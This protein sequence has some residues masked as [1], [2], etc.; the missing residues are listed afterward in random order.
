MATGVPANDTDAE[1]NPRTVSTFTQ[2]ANGT[3]ALNPNG[4]FTYTVSD[5]QG[6]TA[7]GTAKINV[8]LVNDPPLA[9]ND[10]YTTAEDSTLTV[11]A[12]GLLASD[13]DVDRGTDGNP[14]TVVVA[15]VTQ[16]AHGTVIRNSTDAHAG[17]RHHI[18]LRGNDLNGRGLFAFEKN[19]D[20]QMCFIGFV[21]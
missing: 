1:N 6:G 14:L 18:E 11:A 15:P 3:L 8:A 13:T 12:P 5:G 2:S 9:V 4:A 7:V 16:T 21:L 17:P 10:S 19:I 20:A